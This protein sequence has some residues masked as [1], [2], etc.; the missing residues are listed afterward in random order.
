MRM[1][2]MNCGCGAD[3]TFFCRAWMFGQVGKLFVI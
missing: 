3:A 1:E 2:R